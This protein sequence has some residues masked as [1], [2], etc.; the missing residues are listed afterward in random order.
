MKDLKGKVAIVTGGATI[1]GAAV[2]QALRSHDVK[3]ALFDIDAAGGDLVAT[4]DPQ[5]IRFWQVDIADDQQLDRAVADVATQLGRVDF[6]VNLAATYLDDGEKSGRA[7]WLKA[8]D[9][10]VVSA[11]MAARAVRPHMVATGGGAI[12]NFTSISSSVAQTGR[13]LYPVSKAALVQV[14]LSHIETTTRV[15]TRAI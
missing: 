12:V 8:L 7:D 11:V 1:I 6:L 10:N 4:T 13:W 15:A 5:G 14:I 3:V 2:V 9:V